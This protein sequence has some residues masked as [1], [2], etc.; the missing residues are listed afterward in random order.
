VL[1]DLIETY[2]LLKKTSEKEYSFESPSELNTL[3]YEL[4]RV[5]KKNESIAIF[6]LAIMALAFCLVLLGLASLVQKLVDDGLVQSRSTTKPSV[7]MHVDQV[8]Q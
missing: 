5:C 3:G 7:H 8:G 2:Y 4:L 1:H 6:T